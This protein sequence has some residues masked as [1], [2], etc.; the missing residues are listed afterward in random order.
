MTE[1]AQSTPT[2]RKKAKARDRKTKRSKAAKQ[3]ALL[4]PEPEPE[5][6]SE[7]PWLQYRANAPD[8]VFVC[9]FGECADKEFE[10][11]KC[12]NLAQMHLRSVHGI[13]G[14]TAAKGEKK[15]KCEWTDCP[16]EGSE[17]AASSI[18]RHVIDQHTGKTMMCAF[19]PGCDFKYK[20]PEELKYH[21]KDKHMEEF[22]RMAAKRRRANEPKLV[23]GD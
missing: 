2:Q 13:L 5:P 12:R 23:L 14:G 3:A 22:N 4:L 9:K 15:R 18:L 19:P 20:R 8:W 1:E 10:G 21:F 6:E 17:F 16:N 7:S 11:I